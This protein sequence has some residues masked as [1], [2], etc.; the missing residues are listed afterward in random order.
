MF[1]PIFVALVAAITAYLRLVP[2]A[3][4]D[5]PSVTQIRALRDYVAN[6][7][8]IA[9]PVTV[10]FYD[11]GFRFPDLVEATQRQLDHHL[12]SRGIPYK[13]PL[14]DELP[15]S[16]PRFT[17][18]KTVTKTAEIFVLT[19]DD[20]SI[21]TMLAQPA[22]STD[23]IDVSK[24]PDPEFTLD[25]ALGGNVGVWLDLYKFRAMMTYDLEAIHANDLPFYLAQTI[26]DHLCEI[27]FN[28]HSRLLHFD[29][30]LYTPE[31][32]LN[33]VAAEDRVE[34]DSTVL[35]DA[36]MEL[37]TKHLDAIRPLVNITAKI[38]PI[39]VTK[40]KIP[41]SIMKNNTEQLT[42]IYLTTLEGF[43][44]QIGGAH[45]YHLA[46]DKP[47]EIVGDTY[48]TEY[49]EAQK[50]NENPRINITDFLSSMFNVVETRVG[51]TENCSN[52]HLEVYF[53][54]KAFTIR[55]LYL[56]LDAIAENK[57]AENLQHFITICQLVDTILTEE[58]HDWA[59]HLKHVSKIYKSISSNV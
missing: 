56:A 54:A 40:N 20:G 13:Y 25:I 11:T 34:K 43:L 23:P 3:L 53:T 24:P 35:E 44:L 15:K 58:K 10:K 5:E 26:L 28:A 39:D 22:A 27:D 12:K 31:I 50:L 29:F 14:V 6:D 37:I 38:H 46:R 36:L 1:V 48:G 18:N 17:G 2:T 47:K 32:T 59:D 30:E 41:N 49:L 8:A 9:Q 51:L 45:V 57:T 19:D 55:G 33:I 21:E 16:I 42:F 4:I 52:K 7:F